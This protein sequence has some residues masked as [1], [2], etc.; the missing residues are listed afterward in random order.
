MGRTSYTIHSS[1]VIPMRYI[2]FEKGLLF[3]AFALLGISG[4][5][6]SN[7]YMGSLGAVTVACALTS[8]DTLIV[9]S[10]RTVGTHASQA[11]DVSSAKISFAS[12]CLG[13]FDDNRVVDFADFVLFVSVFDT[14]TGD[15]SY[16]ELMDMDKNRIINISDFVLFVS[17]FDTYTGD[18]S[19]NELMD[20][21]KNRIINISDFVLFVSVF[22]T[23]CEQEPPPPDGG[24]SGVSI[25]DA[26]LCAVIEDSLGKASGAP[27]TPAEM[28]TLTRLSA[29]DSGIRDLTGLEHATNLTYLELWSNSIKDVSALSS[30]TNLTVL[31]LQNNSISD[32][33]P[34]VANSGLGQGDYVNV[35]QNPLSATSLNTH[36]PALQGRG[37]HV[38][39]DSSKPA[40]PKRDDLLDR[41]GT[42]SVGD[43]D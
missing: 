41:F 39:F 5:V 28:A 4:S 33:S 29:R 21:D 15:A 27:I 22:D 24:S 13:D 1:G 35:S 38:W 36:I 3:I 34:L 32:L 19:Y 2:L 9:Q 12:P 23:T 26:N 6:P 17:V 10:A 14:Y 11:L 7:G 18:A 43:Y 16:N 31:L 37:V 40:V 42:V 25:P 20:M 8:H 30:L